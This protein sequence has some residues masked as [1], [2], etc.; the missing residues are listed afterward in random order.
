MAARV[1][2]AGDALLWPVAQED[3]VPVQPADSA[4]CPPEL[5][6][7]CS[8]L[9]AR[10]D[11]QELR[12]L[13]GQWHASL[14]SDVALYCRFAFA[15]GEGDNAAA[16]AIVDT[17]ESQYANRL[18]LRGL[19]ALCDI[20]CDALRQMGQYAELQKYCKS[21]LDWC[22]RRGIKASRRENLKFYQQLAQLFLDAPAVEIEWTAKESI[23]PVSREWPVMVPVA[24]AGDSAAEYSMLP[25]L[26]ADRQTFT[27]ISEDDARE[28]RV[29]PVGEP[30]KINTD[31]G[32]ATVRPAMVDR[33]QIG[34]L[35]LRHSLV[36]VASDDLPAPFNRSLG[37]DV[38]RRF[39]QR[40]M[41]DDYLRVS[42]E[43]DFLR[44]D[45]AQRNDS[46]HSPRCVADY[47]A[48]HDILGLL[49]N[50]TSLQ[51]TA[52]DVELRMMDEAI[53]HYFVDWTN[54]TTPAWLEAVMTNETPSDRQAYNL[55][56][57]IDG[58]VYELPEN[59]R[60]KTVILNS[61]NTK[62]CLVNL[63][64]MMIYVP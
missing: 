17:L 58:F 60:Y 20:K 51:L 23:V 34:N 9:A 44:A 39:R 8:L 36:F 47:F 5:V 15:R 33:L 3:S 41:G 27:V 54:D 48:E 10:G 24:L 13:Y 37:S 38:L 16:S 43:G 26:Y 25:F 56:Y 35:V 63:Q 32:K 18:D 46:A 28:C 57:T 42:A 50:E 62:G 19:L 4:K 1:V 11:V 22:Y 61:E 7:R 59:G 29:M 40:V 2:S 53:V 14:P 49:R 6:E 12:P 31:H 21:R 30:L 45:H 64:N 52:S 55:Y